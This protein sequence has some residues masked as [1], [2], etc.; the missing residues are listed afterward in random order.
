MGSLALAS[1]KLI[2]ALQNIYGA[3]SQIKLYAAGANTVSS[4]LTIP[5]YKFKIIS[6]VSDWKKIKFEMYFRINYQR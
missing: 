1:Q 2:P 6:V 3:W 4:T 5:F